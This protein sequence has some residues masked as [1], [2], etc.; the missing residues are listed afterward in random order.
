MA[1]EPL[2]IK[3]ADIKRFT[4]L[5][6]NV[7]PDKFV[8]YIKIAQDIQL[9]NYLGEKLFKKLQGDI[10]N[11]TL[12]GNYETLVTTYIK[13]MLIHWA[14]VE[15]LPWAAYTISNKGVFKHGSENS[16]TVEKNEVDFLQGKE[17]EVANN[18]TQRMVDYILNNLGSFPEY[19]ANGVNEV[20][21]DTNANYG[22][23][24][25]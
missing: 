5:N 20:Q 4:S 23:W 12:S 16:T 14:M 19:M 11:N 25:L 7:D 9:L 6:G 10:L 17:R 13:P 24:Y 18:Y 3:T 2:F 22:G 21:P 15:Y 8:Q 1:T